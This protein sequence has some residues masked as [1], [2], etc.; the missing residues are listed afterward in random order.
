ML[1]FYKKKQKSFGHVISMITASYVLQEPKYTVENDLIEIWKLMDETEIEEPN[2]P[3][4]YNLFH[5]EM[6]NAF[7]SS[8]GLTDVSTSNM[9]RK[10]TTFS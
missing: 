8:P 5:P 6:E 1:Y 9:K 2:C 3:N 7:I 10:K 4:Q